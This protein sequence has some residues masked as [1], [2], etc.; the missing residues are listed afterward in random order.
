MRVNVFVYV[1]ALPINSINKDATPFL[2]SLKSIGETYILENIMGYSFAIQSTL[3]SGKMPSETGHW[4]PY[5]R[6][7]SKRSSFQ[8]MSSIGRKVNFN[9]NLP[10]PLKIA[11]WGIMDR[12]LLYTGAKT[13]SIPWKIIDEF[14][15]R[16]YYYMNELPFFNQLKMELFENWKTNLTY[17]GPPTHKDPVNQ[18]ANYISFLADMPDR[19]YEHES[20]MVYID[21]LDG[22]G[23]KYGT[24]SSVWPNTLLYVDNEL[25][26]LYY[27]LDKRIP[28]F[29]FQVFSDHG[30]CDINHTI[31][32][33]RHLLANGVSIRNDIILFVDATI[34]MIWLENKTC[35]PHVSKVLER[36]SPDKVTIFDRE[37][38]ADILRRYG[39]F[40]NDRKYGDIIVQAKPNYMFFPNF[41]SELTPFRATHGYLPEEEPQSSFLI[42]TSNSGKSIA[43]VPSHIKDLKKYMLSLSAR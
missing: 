42:A 15:I 41:Y 38:D 14:Y 4:M 13:R 22:M 39:V 28:E 3:L 20:I 36:I 9:G 12:L 43:F 24:K 2:Y 1:D 17:F 37:S 40:F 29:T 27:V 19:F 35:K 25:K 34:A 6:F 31:N 30:M 11:R 33:V 32:I 8:V 7:P 16:P 26:K 21:T 23:H 18:T 5:I 10:F